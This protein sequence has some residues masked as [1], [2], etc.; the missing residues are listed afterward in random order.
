MKMKLKII[1]N[2]SLFVLII[3]LGC[4]KNEFEIDE[5]RLNQYNS[6]YVQSHRARTFIYGSYNYYCCDIEY[7]NNKVSK[8]IQRLAIP[9]AMP[10][11]IGYI[12]N[13]IDTYDEILYQGNKVILT[14]K[15]DNDTIYITPKVI[16][17]TLDDNHRIIEKIS[18]TDKDTTVYYYSDNGLLHESI[19]S[20]GGY[21]TITRKFY[22]NSNRNL[23]YIEGKID[24]RGIYDYFIYEYFEDY[25]SSTNG[26]YTLGII[27]GAFIRS[28][29]TN[30][31]K[32]YASATYDME[33]ILQDSTKITLELQ[34][35]ND[36]NP[37]YG[38]CSL[39]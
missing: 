1:I 26:F 6:G 36:G 4:N 30:N 10:L 28:L 33:G 13:G 17:F 11:G 31:F 34:Y 21:S 23:I 25:D 3:L 12:S 7:A 38:D 5:F 37:I 39:I 20:N 27:E 18:S 19:S 8:V 2:S 9:G 16:E 22:F 14:R 29:S 32:I 24:N 35:D 15:V